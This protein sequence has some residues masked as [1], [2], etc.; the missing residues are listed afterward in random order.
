VPLPTSARA[1]RCGG[2]AAQ[3][4]VDFVRCDGNTELLGSA[5]IASRRLAGQQQEIFRIVVAAQVAVNGVAQ[6]PIEQH[7]KGLRERA[8]AILPEVVG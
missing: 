5:E 8:L 4:R 1:G 2:L 3:V 7:A 6:L